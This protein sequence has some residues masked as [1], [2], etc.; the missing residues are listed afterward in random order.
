MK[1]KV[2]SVPLWGSKLRAASRRDNFSSQIR[3]KVISTNCNIALVLGV[4]TPP[5]HYLVRYDLQLTHSTQT[6]Y[7]TYTDFFLGIK[8]DSHS[9]IFFEKIV[10]NKL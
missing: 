7:A 6:T 1:L 3:T 5:P 9:S 10:V 8:L 2:S 4:R